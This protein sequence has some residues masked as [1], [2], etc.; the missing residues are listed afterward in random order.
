MAQKYDI[1]G[2]QAGDTLT[3]KYTVTNSDDT[4]MNLTGASLKFAVA[5]VNPDGELGSALAEKT[6]GDG[7]TVTDAPNGLCEV[8]IED[9]DITAG[10]T[11]RHELEVTTSDSKSYTVAY[12][13][14]RAKQAIYTS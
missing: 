8:E 1:D 2:Y 3:L 13:S 14:I 5:T 6:I 12:G 9:G 7:I 11:Y 10:G 4:A